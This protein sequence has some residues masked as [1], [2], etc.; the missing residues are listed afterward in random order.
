[1]IIEQ[2]WHHNRRNVAIGDIVIIHDKDLDRSEWKLGRVVDVI[3]G[4]DDIV[5]RLL[6]KYKIK[7]SNEFLNV[8]R[9]VQRV[10]VIL[11]IEEQ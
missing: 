11:P 4:K 5:R 6:I 3:P 2:K 8:T 1:M 9:S 10:I 7:G